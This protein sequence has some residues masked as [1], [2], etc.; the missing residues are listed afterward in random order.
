MTRSRVSEAYRAAAVGLIVMGLG[1]VAIDSF[2][3]RIGRS[4]ETPRC[5]P[6]EVMLLDYRTS[7]PALDDYAGFRSIGIP[8]YADGSLF[9]K[10][11][12]AGPG[13]TVRVY[14]DRV[15]RNG[16]VD[17]PITVSPRIAAKLGVRQDSVVREWVL[18]AEEWF[19]VGTTAESFDS[20]FYGPIRTEQFVARATGLW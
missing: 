16:L 11:V 1:A 15:E 3:F 14:P 17:L 19:V 2:P 13:D 12:F 8:N 4:S 7:T 10:R 18:G 20:R 9:V 5:L 6:Y